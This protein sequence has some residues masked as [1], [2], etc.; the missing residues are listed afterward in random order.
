MICDGYAD[1]ISYCFMQFI[2]AL[3]SI[4]EYC[5]NYLKMVFSNAMCSHMDEPKDCRAE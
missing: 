5:L 1:A 4:P 3:Y 2:E